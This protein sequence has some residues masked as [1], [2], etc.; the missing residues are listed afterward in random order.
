MIR[1]D[2]HFN[3]W[4]RRIFIA[5]QWGLAWRLAC[6]ILTKNLAETLGLTSGIE[7]P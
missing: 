2:E 5:W 3:A 6:P 7:A 1:V 4:A